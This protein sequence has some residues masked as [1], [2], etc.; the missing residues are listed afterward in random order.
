MEVFQR[1]L[2]RGLIVRPAKQYGLPTSVRI[3]VGQH[4]ENMLL[5]QELPKVLEELPFLGE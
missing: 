5:F 2:A 1:L 4:H 3:T